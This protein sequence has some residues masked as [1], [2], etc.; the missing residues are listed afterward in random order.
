[1]AEVCRIQNVT[2]EQLESAGTSE[3]KL[4]SLIK[5]ATEECSP[6]YL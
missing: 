6:V 1:M 4:V 5:G 3:K 2:G